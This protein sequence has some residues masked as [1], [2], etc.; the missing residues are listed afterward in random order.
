MK[1]W[2]N[3]IPILFLVLLLVFPSHSAQA[4]GLSQGQV[5]F[6]E[7]FTLSAGQTLDGDLVVL[8]GNVTLEKD[9]VV[10]GSVAL[11]GG[12]AEI[13]A[14]AQIN[15]DMALFGGNVNLAG[16]VNGNVAVFGGQVLLS[17]TAVVHGDVASVG[18]QVHREE[19]AQVMGEVITNVPAPRLTI[20]PAATTVPPVPPSANPGTE[21]EPLWRV[22][23]TL[24]QAIAMGLVAMLVTLF[25]QPQMTRIAQAVTT[26]PLIVGGVGLLTLIIVLVALLLLGITIILL[27]VSLLGA[28]V[29]ILAWL[30]GVLA[31][32]QEVGERFT[33][34]LHQTWSP[35]L[36]AGFGTFLLMLVSGIV[37]MI[38]CIGWL[39]SFAVGLLGLGGVTVTYFGGRVL[40]SAA[41]PA[42]G[43]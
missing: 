12:N 42:S 8:G 5:I 33:Q 16:K 34:M 15:G 18:G 13:A 11:F 4:R 20:P 36:T 24:Y 38:P 30:L 7:N 19:G 17:K 25:L 3:A 21:L 23:K 22:F 10:L 39:F 14:G 1:T 35:V 37:S 32:G 43:S 26:Q 29:L 2:R 31:V 6:G 41:A 27:P 28:L 9:A 40:P